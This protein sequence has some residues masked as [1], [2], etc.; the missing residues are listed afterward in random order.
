[1]IAY[2]LLS[3]ISYAGTRRGRNTGTDMLLKIDQCFT[4]IIAFKIDVE[5]QQTKESELK[6]L[7]RKMD[8]DT[9]VGIDFYIVGS[10]NSCASDLYRYLYSLIMAKSLLI[11]R[12]I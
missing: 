6:R 3:F 12:F 10:K 4:A 11:E 1:M 2:L 8:L 5:N 7:K 9:D